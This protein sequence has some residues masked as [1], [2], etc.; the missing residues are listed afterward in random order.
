MCL[1]S[2]MVQEG[3]ACLPSDRLVSLRSVYRGL[4]FTWALMEGVKGCGEKHCS[5][6]KASF[7]RVGGRWAWGSWY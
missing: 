1:Y 4:P 5:L 7:S 6:R 2:S 3:S